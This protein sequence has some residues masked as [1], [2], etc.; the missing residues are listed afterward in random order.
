MNANLNCPFC[1]KNGEV[2]TLNYAGG[3]PAMFRIRCQECKAATDW[4]ATEPEAWAAWNKRIAG[5]VSMIFN[6]DIFILHSL[7]YCR[8][9]VTGNCTAQKEFRGKMLRIK[10]DAFMVAYEICQKIIAGEMA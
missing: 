10:E 2:D 8:N 7:L 9:H 3:R 6:K 4:Y 1:G 5:G